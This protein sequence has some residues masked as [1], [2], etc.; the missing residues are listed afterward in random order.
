VR[1]DKEARLL[2]RVV[3]EKDSFHPGQEGGIWLS[4]LVREAA[5][6][7]RL[8][9]VRIV[10]VTS[11]PC[12]QVV[13]SDDALKPTQNFYTIL[14]AAETL[15]EQLRIHIEQ[16]NAPGNSCVSSVPLLSQMGAT[17]GEPGH[18]LTGTTYLHANMHEPEAPALVYVSEVSH[19]NGETAYVFGGAT[20]RREMMLHAL[21]GSS[22][23]R[24]TMMPVHAPDP[25]AIDYY[26]AV[27]VPR[28]SRVEVGDT[29]ILA[30]RAQVFVSRSCVAV[31]EGIQE[32]SPVLQGLYDPWGSP[33]QSILGHI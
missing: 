15:Q 6:I 30:P 14:R 7:L 10:G 32:G 18:A 13:D 17:H 19:V 28:H 1:A 2:L 31:V 11:Y 3:S 4:S 22:S 25:A 26:I 12:L 33:T 21:V 29:A 23:E 8:P 20:H 9:N 5:A 16:V 27:S 24:M